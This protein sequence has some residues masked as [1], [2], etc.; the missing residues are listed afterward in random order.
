MATSSSRAAR[1]RRACAIDHLVAD[2]SVVG[3]ADDELAR[4]YPSGLEVGEAPRVI[5]RVAGHAR[6]AIGEQHLPVAVPVTVDQYNS[7]LVMKGAHA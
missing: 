5:E 6:A 3:V 2:H 1:E 4:A 7:V